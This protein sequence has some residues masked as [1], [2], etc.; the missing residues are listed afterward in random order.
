MAL[1]PEIVYTVEVVDR[2]NR[3]VANAT[4]E[5][6]WDKIHILRARSDASGRARFNVPDGI[7]LLYVLVNGAKLNGLHNVY[8][9]T[10]ERLTTD[11]AA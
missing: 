10:V 1:G 2:S 8:R 5:T 11:R 6:S 3:P 4:V 9:G 7:C